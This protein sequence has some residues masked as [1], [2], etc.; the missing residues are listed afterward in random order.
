MDARAHGP[1]ERLQFNFGLDAEGLRLAGNC[2]DQAPGVVLVGGAYSSLLVRS[3]DRPL[4][5]VS[6]LRLLAPASEEQAPA[7]SVTRELI[8]W[9]PLPPVVRPNKANGAPSPPVAYPRLKVRS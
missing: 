3:A 1:Y 9:L 6:L 5:A 7:T 4:S 2:D 8:P